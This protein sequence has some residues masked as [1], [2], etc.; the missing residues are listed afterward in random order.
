MISDGV[1]SQLN[2]ADLRSRW[3]G[4]QRNRVWRSLEE[5]AKSPDFEH[6]LQREFP[7]NASTWNDPLGRRNFL[8]LMSASLALA[9]IYGCGAQSAPKIVPYTQAP[10][11]LIPGKPLYYAT[12]LTLGGIANGILVT[13]H[14]GRPTKVEGNPEHPASL[15]AAD[16]FSQAAILSLYDP[17]R[18]QNV[19]HEGR[20]SAWGD[21]VAECSAQLELQ[22]RKR[23]AGLRI[24]TEST[25]SLTLTKQLSDILKAFPEA[26]WHTFEPV[27]R[28]HVR[29]GAILAFGEDAHS[30]YNFENADV[31]V[32]LGADFLGPGPGHQRYARDFARK[33]RVREAQT[34]MSRLYAIETTPTLTGAAADHRLSLAPRDLEVFALRLAHALGVDLKD[35]PAPITDPRHDKWITAIARD[36]KENAGRSLVIPGASQLPFIHALAHAINNARG[37]I[38]K[39]VTFTAP[40]E[41]KPSSHTDSLSELVGDM[42]AGK[43][44]MLVML[45]GNPIYTAPADLRFHEAMEHVAFRAHLSLYD[46]ETSRLCHWHIPQTHELEAW[47]DA[48]AYDGSITIQQPLILPLYGGKSPHE[49]LHALLGLSSIDGR[50]IVQE[51]WRTQNLGADFDQAWRKALHDGIVKNSALP[52]KKLSLKPLQAPKIDVP[53]EG[54]SVVFTPDPTIW[55]GRFANNGWLQELP[56]PL[57]RLTWDNAALISLR[58]AEKFGLANEQIVD[59]RAG[60]RSVRAPIWIAPGHADE[61]VTLS[62]GYGRTRAGH[63]GTG[64]GY[65]AYALRTSKAMWS[66]A[67]VTLTPT[68]ETRPLATTQRHH[69][70]EGRDLVRDRT[71][72]DFQKQSANRETPQPSLYPGFKNE[73]HAW[74]MLV[75]LNACIGCGACVLGCQSEN[76]IPIVGKEEVLRGREMHWLRIDRY[77]KNEP[78]NPQ[79][80]FQ[81]LAC[82]HC[83]AAP[84]ETVCPV[85]ATSHSSEGLNQM[86]YNRCIGTRYCSNNCPYK[87]RRFNFLQ[88]SPIDSAPLMLMQNPDV[89]VRERGIMEKCTYCVQRI[90]AARIEAEKENRPLRDGEIVTACQG[91]CPTQ[92]IVF[93]DV[94]D[95]NSHVSKLKREPHNFGLLAELGTR[96]R[97][98]Y[99]S[100]VRNPNPE[101]PEPEEAH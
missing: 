38:G 39:T 10:E 86:V 69:N 54:L 48:R 43:V 13:S 76:N 20:V 93:G 33:R 29:E 42:R 1:T 100:H 89:T 32:A 30:I 3:G 80:L 22:R 18:S 7:E 12:A 70:M 47:S 24:L 26:Q 97:T 98:T 91:A 57:T 84:C 60:E 99:L 65:D 71:L 78:G 34:Q 77:Y 74:G 83:E 63:T 55:D 75:D 96:P 5:L 58:T 67:G 81:P 25:T 85:A 50:E 16:I 31:I 95:P 87:V 82:V 68:R 8:R 53:I 79:T 4:T 40:L 72:G 46:D 36:L 6:T 59:L 28:D 73:G 94:N 21:F 23:G 62:L 51:F 27:N 11:E 101:L 44:E 61:C 9:G 2:T 90:N 35:A 14:E 52:E 66:M 64:A 56:K 41:N 19:L 15:G 88:Y 45:G 49:F 17:D 37:N 92:A